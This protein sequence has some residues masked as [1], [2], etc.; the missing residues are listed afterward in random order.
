MTTTIT[1]DDDAPTGITLSAS[2]SSLGEDDGKTDITVTATLDGESTRTSAT[3]VTIGTLSGTATKDTDYAVSTELSTIT[4]PANSESGS[5]TL[6]ITP[7][8][9]S[10]VEGDETI[11]IPGTTTTQVGLSVTSAT[12][13]LTDD[14]KT[15]T[16]PTDDKDAATLSI[17]GPASNVAEGGNAVFT[18]TLSSAVSKQVQVAWSAPLGTDAAEDSDL[19]ATS[20]T[21]TFAANSAAG[22]TQSITITAADDALSEGSESFTVTLGAITSDVSSQLSL[23]TGASSATA[24]ISA[25]DPITVSLSGPATVNEGDATTAYTVSLSPA[26]V[27]PTADLTVSYATA[28]GTAEAGKDYTAK[29]VTLT[30]TNVAAGAQTFTVQTTEDTTDESDETFTVSISSP[31]GG[32]GTTSLGTAKSVTTTISDDDDAPT[33]ITLSASPSSLGEDD[34]KTDITV[35]AT[36]DGGSTRTSATVVTIGT[37]AGTAT[38]DTDYAVSTAL[39]SVTILANSES[40]TGTLAITPTDDSIVEGDE[41]IKIPGTTTTQVGLTVSPATVTL[42]D[43][44]KTTPTPDDDKDTATLSISGPSANVA[45]GAS[46]TF[47]V[48][49]SSAIGSQVQVAWSAP[50]GTD[51]AADSDLSATSGTVTFAANSAAGATQT[52]TITATDDAL[53]ENAESFTVTLG[54]ITSDVSSQLSLKSGASSATATIAE[55]DPITIELSGPDTVE[56]GDTATYTVS[57]SPDGVI[58]TANLTVDFATAD[59]TAKSGSDYTAKSGTLTFTNTAAGSQTVDVQTIEGIVAENSETFTFTISS[60]AGG[61]GQ[62]PTLGTS[63][64]TTTINDD[65]GIILSPT[66]PPSEDIDIQLS[67]APNSV[68]EDAGATNFTVTATN[69]GTTRTEAMTIALALGGTA[70]SGDY[71]APAQVSVT[72]PANQSSG[73]AT[74]TLTIIDDSEVEGDETIIVGGSF[75]ELTIGSA[76]ITVHDDEATYLS[77]SGPASEATEG[78]NASFTVTLSKDVDADVTVTWTATAGTA[79]ASDY[80]TASGSVT[81]TADSGAGA[82]QTITVATIEDDLSET[83]ETF[84][85]EL[86]ADS[87]NRADIVWVKTTAS[88]ATATIAASD[89]ITVELSGPDTVDEG[90]AATYTI[91]LSPDGVIPD[92]GPDRLLRH[93]RRYSHSRRGLHGGIRRADLHAD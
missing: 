77:I 40:G 8:D 13:T 75:E 71:T 11:T 76:L 21:V 19:S 1:D 56:E 64:I 28:D 33:G 82:T 91:S 3:V 32:G 54:A 17:A 44:N 57:L 49:L 59:G 55:S 73:T 84:S 4:I 43:D 80:G 92:C 51:A 2:P 23:K 62:T 30:F 34:G 41:T 69:T 52:I 7:T 68:N 39:A 74:L 24:S 20:G 70:D 26:G 18:V 60:P 6:A 89:P 66:N 61:G 9:D 78:S 16:T 50:L 38:K 25:S 93:S 81:F 88:G 14:D 47:T 22:S 27:T 67:V 36:L 83:A 65:D 29:S 72:I 5:G 42:T 86:G 15:T 37:L 53:S 10:I 58:P 31:A 45:E 79:E 12:V 90:D 63:E 46:A 48:T 85:V 35:T 87:G